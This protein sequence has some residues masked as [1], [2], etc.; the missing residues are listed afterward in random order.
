MPQSVKKPEYIFKH[1]III[2]CVILYSC[3]ALKTK[4]TVRHSNLKLKFI[5]QIEIP[6]GFQF[7]KTTVGGLSGIDRDV[8]TGL[9]YMISDDRSDVNSARFYTAQ[10]KI[11]DKGIDT[12]IFQSVH[13][14]LQPNGQTF[15]NTKVNALQTPDP[16]AMRLFNPDK[17]IWTS[18]GERA[19]RNGDTILCDPFV[20]VADRTGRFLDSL[21]LPDRYNMRTTQNGPRRNGVFEGASFNPAQTKLFVSVEEPL[22]ED[23]RQAATKDTTG[24]IR[25]IQFNTKT[26]K[27]EKEFAY[28]VDPVA[29]APIP[30]SAFKINGV[31]DILALSDHQLIVMERSFSTGR[32]PCT[33]K[34]YLTDVENAEA[35]QQKNIV[36]VKKLSKKLLLNMDDLGV[37]TDNIEG[38]CL[39]PKLSNGNQSLIFISDNNFSSAQ[40]TQVLLFEILR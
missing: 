12:V 7:Q 24:V 22:Y 11:T 3:N 5:N 17:I 37:Y 21:L 33:I 38:V 23:G 20:Y 26:K 36:D 9:Y 18:E 25:I 6:F 14:L 8:N 1:L 16:E 32:T 30:S 34:L 2:V 19:F 39:G 4:S 31:P 28:T 29:H 40:K 13:F 27:A 10:I 15:P 35:I